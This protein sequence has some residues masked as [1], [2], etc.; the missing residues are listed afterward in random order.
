MT[1]ALTLSGLDEGLLKVRS[2]WKKQLFIANS[3][4]LKASGSL[5]DVTFTKCFISLGIFGHG[6]SPLKP[7]P[8]FFDTATTREKGLY[9]S[10]W[11]PI[12]FK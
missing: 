5:D 10:Y 6:R 4:W 11:A 3:D 12:I 8:S 9:L 7:M 2:F 1:T